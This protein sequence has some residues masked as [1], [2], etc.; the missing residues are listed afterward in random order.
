MG[1]R[2][3]E[4]RADGHEARASGRVGGRKLDSNVGNTRRR[5]CSKRS[6]RSADVGSDASSAATPF[7]LREQLGGHARSSSNGPRSYAVTRAI[8]G[9]RRATTVRGPRS[10]RLTMAARRGSIESRASRVGR[11]LGTVRVRGLG[12]SSGLRARSIRNT[13]SGRPVR[14]RAPSKPG[15]RGRAPGPR[16]K[17]DTCILHASELETR[18]EPCSPVRAGDSGRSEVGSVTRLLQPRSR[19]RRGARGH[20][21]TARSSKARSER[22]RRARAAKA[23]RAR[24]RGEPGGVPQR[25][26]SRS[27]RPKR[28]ECESAAP[29]PRPGRANGMGPWQDAEP[30]RRCTS[31]PPSPQRDGRRA[32][33][34][35]R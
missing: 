22:R 8:A 18:A 9:Q 19:E 35:P 2:A 15:R 30:I 14:G 21:P 23:E 24:G 29:S 11:E 31:A 3:K 4:R 12:K 13:T 27:N 5:W 26:A 25:S 32:V 34:G 10:T 33:N 28:A 20:A 17:T 1:R 16:V 7:A 6:V